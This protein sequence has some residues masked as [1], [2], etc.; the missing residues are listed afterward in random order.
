MRGEVLVTGAT[1]NVGAQVV[2]G[3]LAAGEVPRA[4]SRRADAGLPDG[5]EVVR[6]HHFDPATL[7]AALVGVDRVF[8]VW[9]AF[10]AD[11]ADAVAGVIGARRVV[12]LSSGAVVDGVEEQPHPI[13]R[14]HAEVERAVA[15]AGAG[16]TFLRPHGFAANT[17]AWAPD[18]RAGD[19]VRGAYGRSAA[20]AIHEADVAAVAVR[21]LTEDGHAGARYELTGPEVLTKVEQVRVI[22]EVVGRPL[23]WE[24]LSREEERARSLSWLPGSVVDAVLD[25][26]A[27]MVHRPLPPTRTVEEVT[28][29]PARPFREWV[30]DHV[31]DFR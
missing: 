24:E 18:V 27:A 22:G 14:F 5:V 23:R 13:G 15:R 16:W 29:T 21:A 12:L 8:L 20:T 4:L 28:G 7:E 10:T 25:G 2:R 30:A 11:A 1:G 19:V 17:R 6:G 9:P 31:D 3:L 26:Q